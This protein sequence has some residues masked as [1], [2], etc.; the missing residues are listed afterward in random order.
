MNGFYYNTN[1]HFLKQTLP[2]SD[3]G[4]ND[5]GDKEKKTAFR[6]FFLLFAS[7]KGQFASLSFFFYQNLLKTLVF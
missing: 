6:H 4:W 2:G 5:S 7:V 1:N 3:V